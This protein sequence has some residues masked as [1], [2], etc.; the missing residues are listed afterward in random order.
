MPAERG[1]GQQL[2]FGALEPQHGGS[3]LDQVV[4]QAGT[5]QP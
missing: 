1:G 4:P 5:L 3:D 2:D